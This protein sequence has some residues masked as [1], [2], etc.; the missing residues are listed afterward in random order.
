MPSKPYT[1]GTF[2][3]F[4]IWKLW[5][6]RNKRTF[7]QSQPNPHLFKEVKFMATEFSCIAMKSPNTNPKTSVTVIWRTPQ[8]Y[9]HKLNSDG[10]ALGCPGLAGGGGLFR[11]HHG[12]WVKGFYRAI[13]WANSLHA[14]LWAVRDGLSLCI[15]L[16]LTDVE[17]ELDANVAVNLLKSTKASFADYAPL[18]DD[19]RNLMHQIPRWKLKH[20][21]REANACADQLARMALHL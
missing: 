16:Q 19:C 20:C 17:I 1:W 5:F 9:W 12:R 15:Q 2:F 11:D 8:P 10:S 18:A 21:F 6:Q 14:E 3:L 13:G 7:Q 4:A